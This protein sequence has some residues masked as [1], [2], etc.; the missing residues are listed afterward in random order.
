MSDG[1]LAQP[2]QARLSATPEATPATSAA[3][4]AA[5]AAGGADVATAENGH[6][7]RWAC[8][9]DGPEPLRRAQRECTAGCEAENLFCYVSGGR[10]R[11]RHPR[12]RRGRHLDRRRGRHPS[13][14]PARGANVYSS[15]PKCLGFAADA[16]QDSRCHAARVC[17]ERGAGLS[18]GAWNN[19][20][21]AINRDTSSGPRGLHA[22]RRKRTRSAAG[23]FSGHRVQSDDLPPEVWLAGSLRRRAA[24]RGARAIA[25]RGA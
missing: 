25:R 7:A 15:L 3:G 23:T 18:P 12:L 21:E 24:R 4:G 13:R 10:P 17:H 14:K 5:A 1:S 19:I 16:L 22:F 8:R 11:G 9:L 2:K 6:C 20:R